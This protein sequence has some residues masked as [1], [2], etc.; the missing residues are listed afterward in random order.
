MRNKRLLSFI[1][2][3]THILPG[4]DHGSKSFETSKKQIDL[5]VDFSCETIV[6]TSHF[7]PHLHEIDDFLDRRKKSF[8]LIEDYAKEKGI[9]VI[10]G[11]EV[12]L[13]VGLDKMPDI[14]KLCIEGTNVLLLELPDIP[15]VPEMY[16]TLRKLNSKVCVLIA[17][18]DRY[19]PSVI[20]RLIDEECLFQLNAVSIASFSRRKFC[21]DLINRGLVFALGTDIHGDNKRYYRDMQNALT[22]IGSNYSKIQ[23]RMKKLLDGG[24][25]AR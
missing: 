24:Y 10:P 22:K 1:D 13:C 16:E 6:A 7:Y 12:Q 23:K 25:D 14:E 11:A 15:L 19:A 9:N 3:H 17:H 21:M 18:V 2:F 4:M 8:A 20:D 5:A